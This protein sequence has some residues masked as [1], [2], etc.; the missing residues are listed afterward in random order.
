[1]RSFNEVFTTPPRLLRDSSIEDYS[2]YYNYLQERK[3]HG[4]N[5]VW[6]YRPKVKVHRE[7]LSYLKRCLEKN[8]VFNLT[9][10]Q[11]S[12]IIELDCTY[13]GNKSNSIDRIDSSKG[14]E[15]DNCQ[16][17]CVTCNM[18][19]YTH[20]D[21]FFLEHIRKIADHRLR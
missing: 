10:E 12:S 9:H 15:L 6:P 18:M 16:P 7:Y 2:K 19:K 11:F 4:I 3:K 5:G 14:Y 17:C 21:Q 8:R 1:M 20:T 13:C